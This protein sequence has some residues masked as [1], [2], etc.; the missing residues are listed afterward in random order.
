MIGFRSL[1]YKIHAYLTS[2]N[3]P[4]T[5]IFNDW[6]TSES[7]SKYVNLSWIEYHSSGSEQWKRNETSFIMIDDGENVFADV[8]RNDIYPL[9]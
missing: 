4:T 3:E 2:F 1:S 7:N 5:M 9:Q 8:I 6:M